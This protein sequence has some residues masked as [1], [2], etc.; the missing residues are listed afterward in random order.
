MSDAD[1]FVIPEGTQIIIIDLDFENE[2]VRVEFSVDGKVMR[3]WV[4]ASHFEQ[5]LRSLVWHTAQEHSQ[6]WLQSAR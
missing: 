1:T 2:M 5:M 3:P 6:A 4:S